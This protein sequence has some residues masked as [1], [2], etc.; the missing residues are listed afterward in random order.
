MYK[1]SE[2]SID[3]LEGV[4]PKLKMLMA[5]AIKTSPI[6]F[7]I[8][9]GVRTEAEQ[10]KLYKQGRS[11]KG[12]IV[13]SKDGKIRKSNHQVKADGYGYAVD[14]VPYIN[15]KI[16]WD[17]EIAWRKI[18]DHIKEVAKKLGT[19]IVWGGDWKQLID[20]PHYELIR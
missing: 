18:A 6:D 2:K 19:Q 9:S 12:S 5:I 8:T 1:F 15:G 4:H 7:A 10:W 13:T 16:V 11:T 3:K 17:N 14:I 20:K